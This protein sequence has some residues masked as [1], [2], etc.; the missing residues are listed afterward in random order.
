MR[1]SA[2]WHTPESC[3]PGMR[4]LCSGRCHNAATSWPIQFVASR[5]VTSHTG[6]RLTATAA[7]LQQAS[8]AVACTSQA[9]APSSSSPS[10]G[11]VTPG[12][13]TAAASASPASC[14]APSARSDACASSDSSPLDSDASPEAAAAGSAA[15]TP[16]APCAPSSTVSRRERLRRTRG[17]DTCVT[18]RSAGS[19]CRDMPSS[20]ARARFMF[21][22]HAP[23]A[24][25][26]VTRTGAG[27]ARR[28]AA[29]KG[30]TQRL[31]APRKR[32]RV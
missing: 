29:D 22:P 26:R 8:S 11:R 28:I 5:R 25:Q 24:P 30:R 18:P 16:C 21:P 32:E 1:R 17:V 9:A 10:R 27:L 13:D 7:A 20:R 12:L 2:R 31:N 23:R 14:G 15:A 6:G 19:T 4:I 3:V